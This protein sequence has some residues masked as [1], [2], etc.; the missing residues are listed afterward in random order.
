MILNENSSRSRRAFLRTAFAGVAASAAG[1]YQLNAQSK[2]NYPVATP[3]VE[4]DRLAQSQRMHD[5]LPDRYKD[6]FRITKL[7]TFK[8]QPRFLF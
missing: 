2:S 3:V 8:V 4:V 1:A 7:E 5:A 6:K